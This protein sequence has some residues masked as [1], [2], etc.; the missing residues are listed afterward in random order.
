M[1]NDRLPLVDDH[2]VAAFF[3]GAY[4][5][6]WIVSAPAVFMEPSW[7]AAILVY[8]G[9]F[10]PPVSAAAVTWLRGDDVRA[11]ARQ[12]TRWRVG[13]YWWVVALGL[14]LAITAA[15]AGVLAVIGGPVDL[16]RA[17]PS[18][19]LFAV[20]FLF[21]LTVS[22]G[23]NE[24]PGWR[25][26]AQARLNDRYGALTASLVIGV[27][28]AGWHLPYFLA[29]VT[30]HSGFPFVNQIGWFFG[31]LLL[32]VILAWAYNGT[33]SVLIVMVLHA[34]ANSADVILPLAPD[35]I[36]VEGVIDEAA[37]GEVVGV[38]LLVHLLVVV[39]IV[40][41]YGRDGLARGRIP[42]AADVG[43][44]GRE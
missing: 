1:S 38:Q 36:V 32:S 2:P 27:V 18:P 28:W 34:M 13:W 5:Y 39:A 26:F 21:G 20:I 10:G 40:A 15:V 12:I 43:G 4:A 14:P 8:V 19:V 37:V 25:G 23:L 16:G 41:Y 22:G 24:E 29:P 31:I 7:I 42:G 3:V 33:G 17:L 44:R 9:S 11:W 6:T 30:P 35:Q